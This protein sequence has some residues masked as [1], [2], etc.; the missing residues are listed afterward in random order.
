M[1]A[2][3]HSNPARTL[4]GR[5]ATEIKMSGGHCQGSFGACYGLADGS[6]FIKGLFTKVPGGRV[7]YIAYM[8]EAKAKREGLN[9]PDRPWKHDFSSLDVVAVRCQGGIILKSK[10]GTP[11]WGNR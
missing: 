8:D 2:L 4:I 3:T 6:T 10:V 7:Q 5:K 11:L 1:T 9:P